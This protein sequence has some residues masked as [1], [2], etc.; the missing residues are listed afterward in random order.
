M[1][2]NAYSEK[3]L[4]EQSAMELLDALDWA[5]ASATD[6]GMSPIIEPEIDSPGSGTQRN[7]I[8]TRSDHDRTTMPALGSLAGA[9]LHRLASGMVVAPGGRIG[10]CESTRP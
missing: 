2:A 7:T 8:G 5:T 9:Y 4:V 3:A 1:T 10:R 6:E